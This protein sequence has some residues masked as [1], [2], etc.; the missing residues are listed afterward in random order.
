ML[1][2]M[3]CLYAE[4]SWNFWKLEISFETIKTKNYSANVWKNLDEEGALAR[5]Q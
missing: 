2:V 5:F 4:D 3:L 1:T